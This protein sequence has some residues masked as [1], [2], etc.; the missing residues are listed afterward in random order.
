MRTRSS[1]C[2]DHRYGDGQPHIEIDY[3]SVVDHV[4]N[5][6]Q[7][8]PKYISFI[9]IDHQV[10]LPTIGRLNGLYWIDQHNFR[11]GHYRTGSTRESYRTILYIPGA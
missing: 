4:R 8:L 1:S 2:W 10:P 3:D 6:S 11:V 9:H 5:Y 7:G